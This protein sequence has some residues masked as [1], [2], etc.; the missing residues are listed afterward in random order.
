MLEKITEIYKNVILSIDST[1][2]LRVKVEFYPYVGISNR[3]RRRDGQLFVRISDVLRD[4]PLEFQTALAQILIRKLYRRRR[5]RKRP[6]NLSGLPATGQ[7]PG[8][9]SRKQARSRA[10]SNHY[11]KRRNLRS[12]GNISFFKSNL[13]CRFAA[14]THFNLVGKKNISHSRSSRFGASKPSSSANL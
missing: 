11:F 2:N 5:A 3:I 4:A 7:H 13:F 9:N 12:G 10:K 8:E 1:Q 14:E 6:A